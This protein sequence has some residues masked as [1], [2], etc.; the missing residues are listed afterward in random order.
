MGQIIS[1]SL[2]NILFNQYN[3]DFQKGYGETPVWWDK[4]ATL[5]TSTTAT[6]TYAWAARVPRLRKWVGERV[7][8]SL[9]TYS[10]QVANDDYEDTVEIDRNAILDDQAGIFDFGMRDLGRAARKWPDTLL[11][12]TL[13]AGATT[14]CYDGQYFFDTDHPTDLYPG[15]VTAANQQNYWSTSKALTFDNYQ[16]VRAAMMSFAG[17][18]GLPLGVVPDTL[19]VPPQLEV[20]ARLICEA[21]SVSPQTIGAITQAGANDNVLKGTAKVLVIPELANEAT[22][23]YLLDCSKAIKPFVFQQRQA[24]QTIQLR[25]PSDYNVFNRKKFIFGVDTRGATFGGL[26]WLAAKAVA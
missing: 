1:A 18:D 25:S 16:A 23:W 20:T 6:E 11:V 14:L 19:V 12:T 24:P 10:Q 26:W 7:L 13:Q 21:S 5:K 2:L 15:Q 4:I 17:E 8:R 3:L 9:A 22:T